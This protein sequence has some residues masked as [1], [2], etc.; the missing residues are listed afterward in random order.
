M[1]RSSGLH[2]TA[3]R[4][5][6]Y[7]EALADVAGPPALAAG[8]MRVNAGDGRTAFVSRG[9]CAAAAAAVLADPA[10][11]RGRA[12]DVTGPELLSWADAVGVMGEVAGVRV[13]YEALADEEQLAVF[14]GIGIPREP[15]DE[16]VVG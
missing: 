6:Q 16:N 5:A 8:V 7:A 11:H 2:W 10:A 14:D 9:D 13:G 3:L 15:V 4:D 12:Y 1:L